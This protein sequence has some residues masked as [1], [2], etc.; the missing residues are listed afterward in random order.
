MLFMIRYI[1]FL[2]YKH[3]VR[4]IYFRQLHVDMYLHFVTYA[5][6]LA[7]LDNVDDIHLIR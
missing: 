5:V 7:T 3:Y 2:L 1:I 4:I 6:F